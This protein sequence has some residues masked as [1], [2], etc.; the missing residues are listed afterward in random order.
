MLCYLILL[1]TNS[2]LMW[3]FNLSN[4]DNYVNILILSWYINFIVVISGWIMYKTLGN[5][6]G[7]QHI[8]IL[9]CY[10]YYYLWCAAYQF[11]N[12]VLSVLRIWLPPNRPLDTDLQNS[13]A[14]FAVYVHAVGIAAPAVSVLASCV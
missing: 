14:Y 1:L 8:V 11:A 2:I 13:H 10:L 9:I 5:S 3:N 4:K 7:L 6:I 12:Y